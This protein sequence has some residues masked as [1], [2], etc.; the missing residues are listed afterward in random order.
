MPTTSSAKNLFLPPTWL[1]NDTALCH[2]LRSYL[3][4]QRVEINAT[5]PVPSWEAAGYDTRTY[6][7]WQ[8]LI[9]FF[10]ISLLRS[11]KSCRYLMSAAKD[12]WWVCPI[13]TSL[14][15]DFSQNRSKFYT[16]INK[17]VVLSWRTAIIY[18]GLLIFWSIFLQRQRKKNKKI[19]GF[20]M[21]KII[22]VPKNHMFFYC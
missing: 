15:Q 14:S 19:T 18:A 13:Q 8:S 11:H 16:N 4:H 12:L 7:S 21:Y 1:S 20:I 9:F 6:F 17:Y 10:Q 3:Y 22:L 2:C 5:P